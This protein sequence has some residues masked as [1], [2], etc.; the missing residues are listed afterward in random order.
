[1]LRE[2]RELALDGGSLDESF[3]AIDDLDRE[4]AIDARQMRFSVMTSA[5]D[6]SGLP[7][8]ELIDNYLKI[9]DRSIDTGDI[10]FANKSMSLADML[11]TQSRDAALKERVAQETRILADARREQTAIKA[12][13][14]KLRARPEDEALN[15]EVGK[16]VCFRLAQWKPGVFYLSRG[17]DQ[18]LK[19]LAGQEMAAGKDPLALAA[20]ADLWWEYSNPAIAASAEKARKHA[21]ELYRR[22]LPDLPAEKKA[23]A[24]HKLDSITPPK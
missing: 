2:A 8:G 7:P 17:S 16:Y 22:A 3:A 11:A 10:D 5:I 20:V 15:F 12:D 14:G 6:K 4:F 9:A 1:M 19:E 13:I 18:K 24:Q 23:A 21:A